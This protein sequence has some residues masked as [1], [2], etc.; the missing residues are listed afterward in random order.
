MDILANRLSVRKWFSLLVLATIFAT[1]AAR[2]FQNSK[3]GGSSYQTAD[4]LINYSGGFVRRGLFGEL[5]LAI[6]VDG[7]IGIWVLFIIQLSLHGLVLYFGYLMI[8]RRGFSWLSIAVWLGP[9][10]L[11]F[12]AWDAGSPFR[13]EVLAYVVLIALVVARDNHSIKVL[14]SFYFAGTL[15]FA[16]AIFSWEASVL[17]I[18][19]ILYLVWTNPALSERLRDRY[20]Y[21]F[22]FLLIGILG[23]INSVVNHGDS[24]TAEMICDRVRSK[25]YNGEQLCSGA[26]DAI[27]WSSSYTLQKVQISYPLYFGY[28]LLA[29]LALAAVVYALY[30]S[31]SYILQIVVAGSFI[32]LF[33]VVNDYG[34]WIS[35]IVISLAFLGTT[36][37]KLPEPNKT[38]FPYIAIAYLTVW[39]LPHWLDPNTTQW[40][41]LGLLSSVFQLTQKTLM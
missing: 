40:P 33:V 22:T 23:T 18:P 31:S 11:G 25:G 36:T 21:V 29:P 19:L 24:R 20:L 9:A 35:M 10:S 1:I 41:W 12:F 14:R 28:Y 38:W 32:P 16:L 30:K 6:P 4:W 27:G 15:I 3:N 37:K 8:Q 26:I 39:G 17:F 2:Q 5:F 7:S 13:K 34:R